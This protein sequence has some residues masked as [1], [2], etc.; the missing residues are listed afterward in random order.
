[1]TVDACCCFLIGV[2]AASSLLSSPRFHERLHVSSRKIPTSFSRDKLPSFPLA[3]SRCIKPTAPAT[4]TATRP[5]QTHTSGWSHTIHECVGRGCIVVCQRPPLPASQWIHAF[6]RFAVG[7]TSGPGCQ[8]GQ[9]QKL[10]HKEAHP[11]I[12]PHPHAYRRTGQP[13]SSAQDRG[14]EES[15]RVSAPFFISRANRLASHAARDP[16]RTLGSGA[17]GA[18]GGRGRSLRCSC[19]WSWV[20]RRR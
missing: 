17:A 18:M 13:G 19:W 15:P 2:A 5:S 20:W 3:P 8:P 9:R 7:Q 1:M 14:A 10:R 16:C 11:H 4:Y 12:H 6:I